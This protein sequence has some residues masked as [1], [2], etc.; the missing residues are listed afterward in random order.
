VR[1]EKAFLAQAANN[2][3]DERPISLSLSGPKQMYRLATYRKTAA[4]FCQSSLMGPCASVVLPLGAAT[5]DLGS[6]QQQF[7]S[8][9]K[10]AKSNRQ[11]SIIY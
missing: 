3:N 10:I 1:A 6:L 7:H 4:S 11:N 9:N 8:V 2:A 5:L